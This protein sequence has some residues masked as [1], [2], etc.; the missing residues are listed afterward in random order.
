MP[1]N[2]MEKWTFYVA[3]GTE[4]GIQFRTGINQKISVL[5]LTV[6]YE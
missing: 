6:I 1:S 4:F 2:D 5:L 3:M